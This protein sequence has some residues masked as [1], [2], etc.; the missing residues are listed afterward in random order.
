MWFSRAMAHMNHVQRIYFICK[1][2]VD[3]LQLAIKHQS[4]RVIGIDR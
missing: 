4:T 1:S 2:E 3:F